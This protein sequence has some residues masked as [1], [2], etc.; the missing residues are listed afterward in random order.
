[1]GAG[2]S[3]FRYEGMFGFDWSIGK[4]QNSGVHHDLN[5]AIFTS[6]PDEILRDRFDHVEALSGHNYNDVLDGD[7]RGHFAPGTIN[8]R[9]RPP[10]AISSTTS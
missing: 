8:D 3:V 6:D 1:M 7:D 4:G 9:R 10:T 5:K 2:S